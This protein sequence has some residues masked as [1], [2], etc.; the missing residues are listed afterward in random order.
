MPLGAPIGSGL[1]IR[2]PHNI[3]VDGRTALINSPGGLSYLNKQVSNY[4]RK[5]LDLEDEL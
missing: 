1:G 2:N 3:E 5:S 4:A